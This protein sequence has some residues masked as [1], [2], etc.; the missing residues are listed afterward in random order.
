VLKVVGLSARRVKHLTVDGKIDDF[1]KS[2]LL[3]LNALS[4]EDEFIY[5][6]IASRISLNELTIEF[7]P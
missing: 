6:H 4:E 3:R 1:D 5:A 7:R 2:R